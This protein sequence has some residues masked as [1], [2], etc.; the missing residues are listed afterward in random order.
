MDGPWMLMNWPSFSAAPR[1]WVSLATSRLMFPSVSMSEVG[2][3]SSVLLVER[4]SSSDAAPYPSDAARP[5]E[6]ELCE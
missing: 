1:I 3:L 6:S 5:V 4:R 2:A